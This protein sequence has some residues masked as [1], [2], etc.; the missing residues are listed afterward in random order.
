M[1]NLIRTENSG[2]EYFTVEETGESG[3]SVRGLARWLAVDASIISRLIEK[4]GTPD[5]LSKVLSKTLEPFVGKE[6]TLL[7]KDSSGR[8]IIKDQVCAAIAMYYAYEA[9]TTTAEAKQAVQAFLSVGIRSF[10]QKMTGWERTK[11]QPQV[12]QVQSLLNTLIANQTAMQENINNLAVD[13]AELTSI[14]EASR[15]HP[16]SK[17]VIDAESDELDLEAITREDGVTV[18]Q[19]LVAKGISVISSTDLNTI[20]RR[21][22]AFYRSSKHTEPFKRC[23]NIV[24]QGADIEYIRQAIRSVLGI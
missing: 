24:Y 11:E 18:K 16:G 9:R 17:A 4:L 10:C 21:A 22:A 7:S 5:L 6:L 2:V 15:N 14:K 12:D 1:A 23:G 20:S 19:Y 13:R 8:K 3:M